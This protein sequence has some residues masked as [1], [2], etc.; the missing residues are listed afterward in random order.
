MDLCHLNSNLHLQDQNHFNTGPIHQQDQ[1]GCTHGLSC[2]TETPPTST[3]YQQPNLLCQ[4]QDPCRSLEATLS[5]LQCSP[6]ASGEDNQKRWGLMAF[7]SSLTEKACTQYYHNTAPQPFCSPTNPGPSPQYPQ[8][9]TLS[10]PP[11]QPWE[12][13]RNVYTQ[14]FEQL[15]SCSL[16]E[17]DSYTC[18]PHPHQTNPPLMSQYELIQDQMGLFDTARCTNKGLSLHVM[19]QEA[20]SSSPSP[21]FPAG[22]TWRED[23]GRAA[24]HCP[25]DWTWVPEHVNAAVSK[26][27]CYKCN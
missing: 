14:T 9:P 23:D 1:Q 27:C 18:Q 10:S 21:S 7:G 16:L 20:C 2:N 19:T 26:K 11:V 3:M 17:C 5:P 8:T 6:Q 22:L 15:S 12:E 13:S 24:G 25:S 4:V